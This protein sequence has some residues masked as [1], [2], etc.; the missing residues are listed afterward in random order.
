MLEQKGMSL[1]DVDITLLNDFL[2]TNKFFIN[3]IILILFRFPSS[4]SQKNQ[5]L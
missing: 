5:I 4:I 1:V 2:N 3:I